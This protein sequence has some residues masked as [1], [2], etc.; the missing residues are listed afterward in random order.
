MHPHSGTVLFCWILTG[1]FAPG[2]GLIS[3]PSLCMKFVS[4]F[5]FLSIFLV[6]NSWFRKLVLLH[7]PSRLMATRGRLLIQVCSHSL[8]QSL[9]LFHLGSNPLAP[10]IFQLV[11]ATLVS[12]WWSSFSWLPGKLRLFVLLNCLCFRSK[13]SC[14]I[15]GNL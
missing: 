6:T 5:S 14:P 13:G 7:C 15:F 8:I 2:S 4:L 9:A 10:L 11:M 3:A 1:G 12:V